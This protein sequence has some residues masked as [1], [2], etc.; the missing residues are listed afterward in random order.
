MPRLKTEDRQNQII[1][2]ALQIIHKQGFG[3]LTI[4]ELAKKSAISEPAIYR[5]FKNKEEIIL[6][7][8][9]RMNVFDEKLRKHI[10]DISDKE[11]KIY[12]LISFHFEFFQ[13]NP[14]YTS[15]LFSEDIFGNGPALREK[16]LGIITQRRHVICSALEDAKKSRE[17]RGLNTCNLATIILG[18]IRVSVLQWRLSGYGYSII[19]AGN[20]EA[21]TLLKLIYSHK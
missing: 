21:K 8:M 2:E 13:K 6:G 14:E 1:N 11:K 4:K 17:F 7:I 15:I 5:H 18:F 10:D 16:L 12:E 20:A 9:D 3:A 19:E